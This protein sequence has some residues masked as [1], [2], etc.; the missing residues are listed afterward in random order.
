MDLDALVAELLGAPAPF[1]AL[2]RAAAACRGGVLTG[3]PLLVVQEAF[4]AEPPYDSALAIK[5]HSRTY[6]IVDALL[7]ANEVDIAGI[8]NLF[9]G[10]P[11]T[12]KAAD[13]KGE[14]SAEPKG[15]PSADPKGEPSAE[16]S[17][18]VGGKPLPEG[19]PTLGSIRTVRRVRRPLHKSKKKY[20]VFI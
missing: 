17:A 5:Q 2:A 12:Q 19:R 11:P 16:P 14:P 7:Q 1:T 18:A 20:K 4:K 8:S 15:E 9:D 10:G 6:K 13:P 3:G